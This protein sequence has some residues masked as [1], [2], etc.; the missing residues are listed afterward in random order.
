[1]ATDIIQPADPTEQRRRGAICQMAIGLLPSLIERLAT[2]GNASV[3]KSDDTVLIERAF[4]FAELL[5]VR[6]KKYAQTGK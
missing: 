3:N 2:S 5:D 4:A 1:M 6:M